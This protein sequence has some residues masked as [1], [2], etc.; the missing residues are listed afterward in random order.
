[1]AS[2][3]PQDR[4]RKAGTD[5]KP[6]KQL[7]P[8]K[9]LKQLGAG[10]MGTV[11]HAV[12]T[13]LRREVALKVLAPN[14][15]LNET[16]FKRFRTEAQAAAMPNHENI[17]IFYEPGEDK[18]YHYLALEL[19]KGTDLHAL[20]DQKGMLP[21]AFT[22]HVIKQATRALQHAHK[23]GFVHRD[24]KPSN[25]LIN[26]HRVVKLTDMGLAR[27]LQD[28]EDQKVTRDGTTVGTVDYM[29]PEQARNSRA[30]DTRSDIYSLGCT[31]YH[32]LTGEVPYPGGNAVDR[33]YKHV[34]DPIPDVRA[35]NPAVPEDMAQ[36][37]E[38][39]MQKRATDRYQTPAELLE[40]LERLDPERSTTGASALR[41][42]AEAEREDAVR[43]PSRRKRRP[44]RRRPAGDETAAEASQVTPKAPVARQRS[45]PLPAELEPRGPSRRA[46][47]VEPLWVILSLGGLVLVVL[48]LL[49]MSMSQEPPTLETRPLPGSLVAP[50][51]EGTTPETATTNDDAPDRNLSPAPAEAATKT[52]DNQPSTEAAPDQTSTRTPAAPSPPRRRGG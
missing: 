20:I 27:R 16:L 1:M 38:K 7:G 49:L 45:G 25:F 13:E 24:I 33:L 3:A 41:L 2:R 50:E 4:P 12:H 36:V 39:M 15:A 42:L 37:I 21:I 28:M 8:Y 14:S 34:S 48:L 23:H 17:V 19:V 32:M 18:G 9:I 52:E 22:L 10:G 51:P 44:K 40:D 43:A 5:A 6:P 11:Y 29:A 26:K 47:R 31:W 46:H 30:A 35:K